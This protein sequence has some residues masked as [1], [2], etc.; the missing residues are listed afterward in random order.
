MTDDKPLLAEIRYCC[1][2]CWNR[3]N[4]IGGIA[5]HIEISVSPLRAQ[6]GI[7]G[8][9]HGIAQHHVFVE[10]FPVVEQRSHE[11]R[12]TVVGDSACA[13]RPSQQGPSAFGRLA[14]WNQYDTG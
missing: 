7:V 9:D 8:R 4:D 6:S 14:I 13:V 10:S 12:G 3:V 11:G 1:V 2:G 5:Q